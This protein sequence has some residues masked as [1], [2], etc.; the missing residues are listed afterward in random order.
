M[1][2]KSLKINA[3]LNALK[4]GTTVI[5]PLIIIPYIS[6][7]LG[8]ENYGKINFGSSITNYISIIAMLGVSTYAVVEGSK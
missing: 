4:Q 2:D 7:V 3:F 5:F 1:K 8:N 6:R